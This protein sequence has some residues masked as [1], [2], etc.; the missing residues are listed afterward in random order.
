MASMRELSEFFLQQTLANKQA[1]DYEMGAARFERDALPTPAQTANFGGAMAP[2][3]AFADMMGR[4]PVTPDRDAVI[5]EAFSEEYGPSFAQN[6]DEGNF[7]DAFLQG[8]GGMGDALYAAGPVGAAVGTALKV[9]RAASKASKVAPLNRQRLAE[10]YPAVGIPVQNVDKKSGKEFLSKGLSA[11]ELALQAERQAINK[12]IKK[13]NY[14]PYFNID[15]RYYADPSKYE[16]SGN[17]LTDTLP[18]RAETIAAKIEKFDTPEGRAALN[19]AFDAGNNPKAQNWYAMGQLEDEFI[20]VLGEEEGRK[21]FKLR[22]ADAMAATTGGADPGSNLLMAAYGNFQRSKSLPPGSASYEM[23]HPIG[24]RYVTGNMA[25]YDKIL[26]KEVGL[27][28]KDQPKRFNFSANFLG[29][30]NRATIDEQMTQGLTGGKF[31]APPSLSYGVIESIVHDEAKKR[32]IKAANL[33]DV[34][35]AGFKG[36]EG[37]PM[38]EWVNEMISRTS[39]VTGKTQKEVLEGF[40]K[41]N[42]P[43]YGA[44]GAALTLG[45]LQSERKK[46]SMG[47]T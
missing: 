26:N 9:P 42:M 29:D 27:T 31:N 20:R 6:L 40:V 2:G 39:Q 1:R 28:A 17:T 34:S 45:A 36:S 16:I 10:E 21:Q 4:Y 38:I 23:P 33:Q 35:W 44:G 19:A 22:F 18:K 25:M 32:G 46:E 14:D 7:M 3:A 47:E 11:E 41:G 13:G 15:E 5:T 30:M 12:E 8:L 24:G 37:K 43:M